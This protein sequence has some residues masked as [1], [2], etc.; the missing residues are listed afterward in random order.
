MC[1]VTLL[2]LYVYCVRVSEE[3]G[4]RKNSTAKFPVHPLPCVCTP[5]PQPCPCCPFALC[6]RPLPPLAAASWPWT[7]S[8]REGGEWGGALSEGAPMSLSALWLTLSWS[9]VCI[10]W[11]PP[12]MND[13]APPHPRASHPQSPTPPAAR[14]WTPS[15]WRTPWRTGLPTASCW[16]APPAWARCVWGW[17]VERENSS[18][19]LGGNCHCVMTVLAHLLAAFM[20]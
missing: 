4:M 3:E 11:P 12:T 7:V 17:N 18:P 9:S 1:A 10:A 19:D 20:H 6:R 13:C 15:A 5:D 8:G 14:G 2:C 16:S